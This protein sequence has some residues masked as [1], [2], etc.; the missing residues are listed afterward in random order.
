MSRGG[1]RPQHDRPCRELAA[2]G[3]LTLTHQNEVHPTMPAPELSGSPEVHLFSL[4]QRVTLLGRVWAVYE[5]SNAASDL[6]EGEY[7]PDAPHNH[8]YDS[9]RLRHLVQE[10]V[11]ED[12]AH[13][14]TRD[15]WNAGSDDFRL[16][17]SGHG[18]PCRGSHK[19][20]ED[21]T[22]PIQ[23]TR[24]AQPHPILPD[25]IPL[26]PRVPPRPRLYVRSRAAAMDSPILTMLIH[27]A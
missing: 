2:P 4:P 11:R 12:S 17:P 23:H 26:P 25:P 5:G 16:E 21:D 14:T 9:Q 1:G 24:I 22:A 15:G 10:W 3:L 8:A 27:R 7:E 19:V 13:C 6:H 18:G 20:A